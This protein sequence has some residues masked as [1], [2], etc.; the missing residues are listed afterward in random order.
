MSCRQQ[1]RIQ[2]PAHEP[3]R[4]RGELE[5]QRV[6]FGY[7]ADFGTVLRDLSLKIDVGE[8][9]ALVGA[10]GVGKTTLSALIPRFYDAD[11]GRICLDGVDI[12]EYSLR[13]LRRNIG[14]V[15]QDVYLFAATVADNI[16]YGKPEATQEEIIDAAKKAYAHDFIMELPQR[17]DTEI[18]QRGIQAF[19]RPATAAKHRAAVLEGS[20]ADHPR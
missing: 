17:Y 14:T 7:R 9:V 18:G 12:R 19:R 1:F 20:A 15:D 11:A 16:R 2:P 6:S 4:V 13:A 3:E 5:L 8:Y 10:S